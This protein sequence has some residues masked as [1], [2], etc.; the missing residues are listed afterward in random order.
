MI[1]DNLALDDVQLFKPDIYKD[2]RG[3]FTEK[4]NVNFLDNFSIKQ[5]NQSISQKNVFR[6]FHFQNPP[7][8]QAKY[9]WVENGAILD[10]VI[11]IQ[12]NSKQYKKSIMIELNDRNNFHLFIPKGFAHGFIA[13]HNDSKVYY[14]VDNFY[15]SEYDSGVNY[16]DKSLK[17]DWPINID[18]LI[19]SEKDKNLPFL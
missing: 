10:I 11:N 8:E 2:S 4:L 7:Y 5:I 3:V 19:V 14:A 9:V 16:G 12:P 15:S 13:I 18:N 1:I 17:I 6:G